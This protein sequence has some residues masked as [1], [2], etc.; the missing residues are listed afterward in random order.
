M[1]RQPRTIDEIKR[2]YADRVEY[3]GQ[4][5]RVRLVP[6]NFTPLTAGMACCGMMVAIS[7]LFIQVGTHWVGPGVLVKAGIALG[8]GLAAGIFDYFHTRMGVDRGRWDLV[9]DKAN[10]TLQLPAQGAFGEPVSIELNKVERCQLKTILEPDREEGGRGIYRL[11][12][13]CRHQFGDRQNVTSREE[14]TDHAFVQSHDKFQLKSIASWLGDFL[15]MNLELD[16]VDVDF[17]LVSARQELAL[18][19]E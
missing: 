15:D 11:S 18:S 7:F 19:M 4:T 8:I 9:L 1:F 13:V 14:F 12:V 17:S 10:G 3:V 2:S 5:Q 6:G 16:E